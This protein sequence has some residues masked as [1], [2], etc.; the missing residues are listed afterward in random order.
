[1]VAATR[2]RGLPA[3]DERPGGHTWLREHGVLSAPGL[4][5]EKA[6]VRLA[7]ALGLA[8]ADGVRVLY[9]GSVKAANVAGIMAKADVDGALVGG[10][11]LQVEEFGGICRF[12]DMPA[13]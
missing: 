9:G 3:E 2:A 4:A 13:L 7:L 1:M 5:P 6:R 11:S 8:A 12:H 10:A